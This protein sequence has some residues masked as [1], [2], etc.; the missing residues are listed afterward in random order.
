PD[1]PYQVAGFFIEHFRAAAHAMR[2]KIA[3]EYPDHMPRATQNIDGMIRIIERLIETGHAYTGR[4]GAVY[5]DVTSFPEYGRLSGNT[6]DK[7]QAGAGGRVAAG[8][9]AAKRNPH[10]FLLWKPDS[11]HLMRWESPW[12]EGYPGWHIECSAMAMDTHR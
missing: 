10:D 1:D 4:D 7:L 8:E 3:D 6:L 2:L 12:G 9:T 5:Y 11:K